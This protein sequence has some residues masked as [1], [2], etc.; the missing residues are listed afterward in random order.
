MEDRFTFEEIERIGLFV[1]SLSLTPAELATCVSFAK[2][3]SSSEVCNALA[4]SNQTFKNH[5]YS[6]F[7]KV[8]LVFGKRVSSLGLIRLVLEKGALPKK[9]I[10]DLELW[11]KRACLINSLSQRQR[12]IVQLVLMGCLNK[13]IA[14]LLNIEKETV[15]NHLTAA[16]RKLEID[17]GGSGE[18]RPGRPHLAPLVLMLNSV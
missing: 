1:N 14:F 15:K 16:Y 7:D 13:E 17:T 18:R 10:P 6:I 5:F 3:N 2:F 9:C 12:E 8:E 11:E 4:I